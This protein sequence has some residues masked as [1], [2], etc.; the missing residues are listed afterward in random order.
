MGRRIG[1]GPF[2]GKGA[3]RRLKEAKRAAAQVQAGQWPDAP[4]HCRSRKRSFLTPES[5]ETELARIREE[6]E[7]PFL[8][9]P[10]RLE[11]Y[12]YR[13]EHCGT[14]HLTKMPQSGEPSALTVAEYWP[15]LGEHPEGEE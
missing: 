2:R 10:W 3:R 14:Y 1:N 11:R 12:Y 7:D 9:R 8:A 15:T 4:D 5:A 6:Q 13:C